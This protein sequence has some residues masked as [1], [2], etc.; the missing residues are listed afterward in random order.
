MPILG[1]ASRGIDSNAPMMTPSRF[2]I[3][4]CVVV[5]IAIT[6]PSRSEG[7]VVASGYSHEMRR[8]Q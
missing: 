7:K 4:R 1:T 3:E 2:K 5:E 8:E 6:T